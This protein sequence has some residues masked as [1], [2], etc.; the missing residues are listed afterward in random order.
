MTV[1]IRFATAEDQATCIDFIGTL[2]GGSDGHH[3][4]R[5]DPLMRIFPAKLLGKFE[6][7]GTSGHAANQNQVANVPETKTGI[8]QARLKRCLGP[9]VKIIT[10]LL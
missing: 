5:V 3:F 1:N 10:N 4:I 6:Y 7:L 9:S 2:N 8:L